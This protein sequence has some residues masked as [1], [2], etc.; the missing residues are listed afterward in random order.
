M[1]LAGQTRLCHTISPG[2]N[3]TIWIS[4]TLSFRQILSLQ[5]GIS[6]IMG[7]KDNLISSIYY[8]STAIIYTRCNIIMDTSL[9]HNF[10]CDH[11]EGIVF[12]HLTQ[13]TKCIKLVSSFKHKFYVHISLY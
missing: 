7:S 2:Q 6:V 10:D 4:I 5:W 8:T 12:Y 3:K 1:G 13:K 11:N 9:I